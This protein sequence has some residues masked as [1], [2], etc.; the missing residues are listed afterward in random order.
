M[1]FT[2]GKNRYEKKTYRKQNKNVYHYFTNFE[3]DIDD[4]SF[5][6]NEQIVYE[7]E[8]LGTPMSTYDLSKGT[9]YVLELDTNILQK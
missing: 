8:L 1:E 2:K 5:S 6:I 7:T 9:S 3:K 4:I